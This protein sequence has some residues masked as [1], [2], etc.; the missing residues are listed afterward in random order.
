M[1]RSSFLNDSIISEPSCHCAHRAQYEETYSQLSQL[2]SQYRATVQ[3][4]TETE[5][6][7]DGTRKEVAA[8]REILTSQ[9]EMMLQIGHQSATMR[10]EIGRLE[11]E[12]MERGKMHSLEL[13][14]EKEKMMKLNEDS[15]TKLKE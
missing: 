11:M 14:E 15:V 8:L 12:A 2:R 4:Q 10:Q 7:L 6:A 5:V 1:N 13:A 3:K 9:K